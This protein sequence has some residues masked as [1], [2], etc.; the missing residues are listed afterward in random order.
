MT[1]V[2]PSDPSPPATTIHSLMSEFLTKPQ[3][4][5]TLSSAV[6]DISCQQ[7][8]SSGLQLKTLREPSLLAPPTRTY[9]R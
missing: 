7:L 6:S 3:P 5:P 2:V 4:L 1:S 8:P 9:V